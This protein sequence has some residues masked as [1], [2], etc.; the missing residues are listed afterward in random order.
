MCDCS[1]ACRCC[2]YKAVLVGDDVM[3]ADDNMNHAMDNV[4]KKQSSTDTNASA[5]RYEA[6]VDASYGAH[7]DVVCRIGSQLRGTR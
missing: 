3:L 6:H 2:L 1:T 5:H 7:I 4:H